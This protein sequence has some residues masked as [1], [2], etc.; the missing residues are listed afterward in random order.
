MVEA[1]RVANLQPGTDLLELE[2]RA[3]LDPAVADF[4]AGGAGH[5]VTLGLNEAAW[6][7]YQL[8][9]RVMTDVRDASASTIVH[10]HEL[11]AP[12]LVSPMGLHGLVCPE[13]ELASAA[14]ARRA[15][16]GYV[17]SSASSVAL[18]EIAEVAP[19]FRWFQLYWLRDRDVVADLVRRAAEAGYT[20]LCLTVDAPVG[21]VRLRDRRNKFRV[22]NG[23]GFANLERYGFV[24][25]A[26]DARAGRVRYIVDEVDPSITWED[27]VW[28]KDLSSLPIIV[29][30]VLRP[31]DAAAAAARGADV[32]YISN[33]GGRQLDQAPATAHALARAS[34]ENPSLPLVVDGGIRSASAIAVAISL[35]ATLVGIGRPVMWA[36]ASGGEDGATELL[37]GLREELGRVLAL[38][39]AQSLHELRSSGLVTAPHMP[40]R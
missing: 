16:I 39:G 34:A 33:H 37:V 19:T 26:N 31:E 27:L 38:L 28:L 32:V 14:A 18:E 30:G 25:A 15:G 3:H 36:L 40:P 5:E 22:P 24:P 8:W 6:R 20:G 11:A 21:A 23:I 2:A 7:D 12:M 4:I 35:G 10:G 29:K 9:P 1:G 17:A 13:G